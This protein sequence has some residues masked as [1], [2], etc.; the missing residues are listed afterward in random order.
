MDHISIPP[1]AKGIRFDSRS[2]CGRKLEGGGRSQGI[3]GAAGPLTHAIIRYIPTRICGDAPP[4]PPYPLPKRRRTRVIK[5]TY[6]KCPQKQKRIRQFVAAFHE[7]ED[8]SQ[9][10]SRTNW[11]SSACR[12][13]LA[14]RWSAG[15]RMSLAKGRE[16]FT[17]VPG[18]GG[19]WS[20]SDPHE[21]TAQC[22]LHSDEYAPEGWYAKFERVIKLSKRFKMP[23]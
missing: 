20:A 16:D 21:M 6:P 17:A 18:L 13:G 7:L 9:D 5:R 14:L 10:L 11:R 2:S 19:A 3:A 8:R 4:V 22:Y 1:N 15:W 23:F 12:V